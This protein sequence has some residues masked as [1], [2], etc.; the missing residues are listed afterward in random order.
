MS[1]LLE[2]GN[3]LT[4]V[5]DGRTGITLVLA[6][7]PLTRLNYF[8]G[9]F[10]RAEHLRREQDY[11]RRL[12]RYANQGLGAGIVYGF[13]TELSGGG[14]LSIG[15]GLAVD[16][17]GR[18]LLLPDTEEIEIA[19]LLAARAKQVAMLKPASVS[20]R[21]GA[22]RPCVDIIGPEGPTVRAGSL[23]YLICVAHVESLCGE[24]DVFGRLCEQACVSAAER[25]WIVEGVLLRA[26]P[27]RLEV[28]M[29]MSRSVAL[30]RR[31]LRSLVASAYY[32]QEWRDGGSLI[33]GD[34]L[35]RP[36]TW[37]LGAL[38]PTGACVPLGVLGLRGSETL[39]FDAWTARRERMETPARAY[40]AGIMRMRSW[41]AYLAQILQFQCQLHDVL[42]GGGAPGQPA[43]PCSDHGS[44][45]LEAEQVLT[46]LGETFA[47]RMR[48]LADRGAEVAGAAFPQVNALRNKLSAAI[49]T[50]AQVPSDRVLISN[51]IVELPP[52]GYL[53]VVPGN[54]SGRDPGAPLHGRRRGP[55]VLRGAGGFRRARARRGAAHGADLTAHG[56][57]RTRPEARRRHPGPRRRTRRSA[58][59]RVD[60]VR[61]NTGDVA[62]WRTRE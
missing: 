23:L 9:K 24:E 1:P 35:R 11:V 21:G 37:C 60:R 53:P 2:E 57:G 32:A 5:G 22:F 46:R 12:V 25:P 48:N 56:A 44:V 33:S 50:L 49:A 10:L 3:E 30:D 38:G 45:L 41:S 43:D 15:A 19:S 61:G 17:E 51:G 55:A 27:L 16:G 18:T 58:G 62:G 8:D 39:F 6:S 40:W 47:G 42:G 54:D 4:L 31:H 26:V 13:S 36:D 7:S 14:R 29:A 59:A 52:A 28:P 20:E 34:G